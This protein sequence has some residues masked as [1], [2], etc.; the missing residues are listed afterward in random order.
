MHNQST[1]VCNT[2]VYYMLFIY[3]VHVT[4]IYS[5]LHTSQRKVGTEMQPLSGAINR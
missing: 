3:N 4:E 1:N 5:K 2:Y